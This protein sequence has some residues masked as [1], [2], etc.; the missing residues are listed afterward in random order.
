MLY[1]VNLDTIFCQTTEVSRGRKYV[2][3]LIDL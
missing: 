2:A 3:E 1:V